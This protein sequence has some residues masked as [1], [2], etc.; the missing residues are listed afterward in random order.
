MNGLPYYKAYPK[1]FIDGCVGMDFEVKGAY[2]ILIDLIYM[3]GGKLP[4]DPRYISGVLGCSVRKWNSIRKELIERRKIYAENEIISNFRADKELISS[5]KLQDKNSENARRSNKNNNLTK[6]MA[7][8]TRGIDTDTDTDKELFDID[9]S[10]SHLSVSAKPTRSKKSY[11]EDFEKWWKDYPRDANMSKAEAFK[12]WKKLDANDRAK[13]QA[14]I[15]PFRSWI[16][17]QQNYR[18]LHACRFLSQR[19]FDGFAEQASFAEPGK[20]EL[21]SVDR[22]IDP[23]IFSAAVDF[24]KKQNP[25]YKPNGSAVMIPQ[26]IFIAIDEAQRKS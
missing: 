7:P 18:T 11:S 21:V 5:R 12:A 1:D 8:L 25:S 4:D 10:I 6:A 15:A 26:N 9:K 19:R 3:Q 2:R 16:S 24:L 20:P 23:A 17:S 14:A 13:A 22:D